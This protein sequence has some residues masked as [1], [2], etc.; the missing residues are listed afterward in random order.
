MQK[1]K[2]M[3]TETNDEIRQFKSMKQDEY[4]TSK[5]ATKGEHAVSTRQC[6]LV[7]V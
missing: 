4:K 6:F 3:N 1:T 7:F 5:R 2:K